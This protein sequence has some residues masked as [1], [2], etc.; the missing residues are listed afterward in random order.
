MS[1][2]FHNASSAASAEGCG[3]DDSDAETVIPDEWL[4]DRLN[5][6]LQDRII[7]DSIT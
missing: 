4:A 2:D 6:Y 5:D 1:H 7:F 3:S